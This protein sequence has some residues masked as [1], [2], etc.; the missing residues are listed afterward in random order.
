MVLFFSGSRIRPLA[1]GLSRS[2]AFTAYEARKFALQAGLAP[3]TTPIRNPESNGMAE[4]L[5]N[6]I[7]RDYVHL[8]R[9]EDAATVMKLLPSWLEDYNETHPHKGAE[10][11]I[12]P[13]IQ[14]VLSSNTRVFG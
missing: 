4:S 14:A 9:L 3:C 10:D 8:N 1:C 12:A 7:K 2:S 13:G 6:T 5:V 11:A